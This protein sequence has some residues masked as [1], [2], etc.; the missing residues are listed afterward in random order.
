MVPRIC[1]Q[2]RPEEPSCRHFPIG[3]GCDR[4]IRLQRGTKKLTFAS[5][6]RPRPI[7]NPLDKL[8][9]YE[10]NLMTDKNSTADSPWI[11]QIVARY[12]ST[13]IAYATRI[14][15]NLELAR[16]IVQDVF[17]RLCRADPVPTPDQLA[18]W[19]YTVCRHRALDICKKERRMTSLPHD[20]DQTVSSV[21]LEPQKI[22]EQHETAREAQ[23]LIARLPAQQ[24]EVLR[25]KV[26][27][28]RTYREISQITGLTVS[29]VGYLL[30]HALRSLRSEYA[31]Q[32]QQQQQ[33][34]RDPS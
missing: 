11:G 16:D 14:V 19:L 34:G 9:A 20:L 22:A 17:L 24:Q 29:H 27:H 12:E 13:L 1:G 4:R 3:H 7:V 26:E 5:N 28:G 32:Q 15:G 10:L 30:H 21:D 8:P 6:K 23:S 2:W 33:T 31:E 25:L 18:P